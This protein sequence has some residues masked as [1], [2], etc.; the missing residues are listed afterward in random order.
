MKVVLLKLFSS[1]CKAEENEFVNNDFVF[2]ILNLGVKLKVQ[3]YCFLSWFFYSL[4]KD[5]LFKK[6]SALN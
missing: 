2:L 3:E 6:S 4:A 1:N 5:I